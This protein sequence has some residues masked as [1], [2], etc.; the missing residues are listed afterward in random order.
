[1]RATLLIL[2]SLTYVVASTPCSSYSQ[3]S[4][5]YYELIH[6][7][8]STTELTGSITLKCRDSNTAEE[9]D[10]SEI[11]FFLNYSS[12]TNYLSLKEREDIRVVAVGSTAIKFNLTCKYDG[13]Y[14][15]GKRGDNTCTAN[16]RRPPKTFVCEWI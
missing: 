8:G 5:P 1:M 7:T 10:I 9:L 12:A 2:I 15:C 13:C 3:S 4:V 11:S 16:D 14:T 6:Q